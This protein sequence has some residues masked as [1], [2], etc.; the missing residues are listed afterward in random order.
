MT[1]LLA[2]LLLFPGLAAAQQPRE[3]RSGPEAPALNAQI[4]PVARPPERSPAG[5]GA[6]DPQAGNTDQ[7]RGVQPSTG[8][9]IGAVP[10][11]GADRRPPPHPVLPGPPLPGA[12]RP[13]HS[14]GF[15]DG[16]MDQV[17]PH[18]G[19]LIRPDGTTTDR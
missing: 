1:R 9:P 6:G 15:F 2:L 10:V 11:P 8:G 19:A 18:I 13:E 3:L 7:I 16:S 17:P 12:S 14:G 5:S 4:P